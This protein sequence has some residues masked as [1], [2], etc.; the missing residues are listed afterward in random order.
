M[1]TLTGAQNQA[2]LARGN[3]LIV[4]GAGTG[5]T[6]TLIQR[7]VS[8]LLQEDCSLDEIL[9]VTFTEGAAAQMRSR[10]REELLRLQSTLG[11]HSPQAGHVQKQI[12]LLDTACIG[13]LH[14]FCLEL[15]RTHF[16]QLGIDPAITVLDETQTAPLI[17]QTL[18]ALF[19]RYYADETRESA[20]VE[21]LI[22]DF[23]GGSDARIRAQIVKLHRY[24]QALDNP[25]AWLAN[26]SAL[27]QE[28]KP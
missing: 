5:K 13:T 22:R 24:T 26:Q 19:L 11:E 6:S 25:E 14:S 8:L 3:V 23:G 2:S 12:A 18:E 20:A 16:Y 10:I 7:C 9:M 15:V 4:A 27:Y 1:K 21:E 17:S 28:Q